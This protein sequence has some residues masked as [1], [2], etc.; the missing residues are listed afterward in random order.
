L[1]NKVK[2]IGTE[3]MSPPLCKH[4]NT[5]QACL[6]LLRVLCVDELNDKLFITKYLTNSVTNET[7]W[8]TPRKADWNITANQTEKSITGFVGLKNPACTCYINSIMQ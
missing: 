5:R 4:P 8:R 6:E 2:A 7:D 3:E 1:F